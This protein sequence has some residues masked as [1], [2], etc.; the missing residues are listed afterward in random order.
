MIRLQV[1][2]AL[3][4]A[5]ILIGLT[6]CNRSD[7]ASAVDLIYHEYLLLEMSGERPP[8][9][10]F[11]KRFPRH[12]ATIARQ[13]SFHAALD[14][15]AC[16]DK[17]DESRLLDESRR[18]CESFDVSLGVLAARRNFGAMP[19]SLGRYELLAPV[20]V[21]TYGAVYKARDPKLDR[22]VAIKIPLAAQVNGQYDRERF[23]REARSVARLRHPSIV[24]LHEIG[25]GGA[26]LDPIRI[27]AVRVETTGARTEL[28]DG[29]AHV[30]ADA[31]VQSIAF[32]GTSAVVAADD[33]G[34]VGELV[35]EVGGRLQ[36]GGANGDDAEARGVEGEPRA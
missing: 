11:T 13:I 6:G 33:D 28:I 14:P 25:D 12:A 35:L 29:V 30:H 27:E 8:L 34:M 20:G 24:S 10:S 32:R 3:A 31:G 7:D 2:A 26:A 5:L 4:A 17:P 21:G 19:R 22:V 16:A 1:P 15:A 9:E 36:P 23:L 18:L